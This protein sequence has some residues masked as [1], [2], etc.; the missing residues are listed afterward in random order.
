MS[1]SMPTLKYSITPIKVE[2][3]QNGMRANGSSQ[4][5]KSPHSVS[6]STLVDLHRSLST[7]IGAY[8]ETYR[9]RTQG[10]INSKFNDAE[11]STSSVINEIDGESKST[12]YKESNQLEKSTYEE[13]STSV[14]ITD[15]DDESESTSAQES[16]LQS[17]LEKLHHL[18]KQLRIANKN[19]GEFK[20][21]VQL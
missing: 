4:S 20:N 1:T 16:F 5:N 10:I 13:Q 7:S 2:R 8:P 12:S 18:K 9:P 6:E 19:N 14:I 15:V 11:Q 3:T 17:S 21:E